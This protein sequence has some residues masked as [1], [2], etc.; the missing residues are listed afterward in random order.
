MNPASEIQGERERRIRSR[1][2]YV[3]LSE[4]EYAYV[5]RIANEEY[6]SIEQ[7]VAWFVRRAL[8]DLVQRT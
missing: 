3:T 6:R 7:Q 4:Q 8:D 5:L 1:R 2:V